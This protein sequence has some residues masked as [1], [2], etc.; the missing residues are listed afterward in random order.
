MLNDSTYLSDLSDDKYQLVLDS[1]DLDAVL[2]IVHVPD[3]FDLLIE[4]VT[5]LVVYAAEGE[6]VEVWATDS[7]KPYHVN[8]RYIQLI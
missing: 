3:E 5:G 8:S 7:S 6:Y 2:T 4:D 1:Q